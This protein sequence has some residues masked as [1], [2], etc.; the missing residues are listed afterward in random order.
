M[1]T[2]YD[3]IESER[4]AVEIVYRLALSLALV[5]VAGL[6][7]ELLSQRFTGLRDG[8]WPL[9][10][11]IVLAIVSISWCLWSLVQFERRL[12]LERSSG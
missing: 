12:R 11:A 7:F 3:R 2:P 4:R 10:F 9:S 8:V 6:A 1:R 5:A